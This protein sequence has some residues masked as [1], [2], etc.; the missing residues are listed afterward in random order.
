MAG[1]ESLRQVAHARAPWS[2]WF[3]IVLLFALFGV[4]VL[5]LIGP[6]PRG[7]DYE[8][9]RAKKRMENLKTLRE[10]ADK[11]LNT[12]G[13]ID[14]NK[15]VA[16]IPIERAMELTVAD[17]AKQKPAPAG[18]IATPAAQPTAS[19]P[20]SAASPAPATSPKPSG[21]Q[22][23]PQATAPAAPQGAA[24]SSPPPSPAAQASASPAA[25]PASTSPS[26]AKSP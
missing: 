22:A 21:A 12:Y 20:A 7:S 3:G 13:W 23:S 10:E 4:I 1:I 8:E 24:V 25:S 11:S 18:P 14:K 5:A 15:G 9:V 6:T 17:L 26:P 19:A 2:A 16:R